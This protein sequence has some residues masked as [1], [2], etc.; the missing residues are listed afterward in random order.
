[1][2]MW[3]G[4]KLHGPDRRITRA[5]PA[6]SDRSP[7]AP[8]RSVVREVPVQHGRS[9]SPMYKPAGVALTGGGRLWRCLG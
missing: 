3:K 5:Q 6:E 1:M 2:D 8:R 4:E 7:T 9:G